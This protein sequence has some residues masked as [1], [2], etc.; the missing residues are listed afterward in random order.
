MHRINGL[1]EKVTSFENLYHA[2]YRVLRGKR[3]Q[4]HAGDFF[5]NLEGNLLRLQRELRARDY[6]PGGYRTFWITEPKP[7]LISAAPF[8][9]RVVHHALVNVIEPIFEAR[10]ISHSYACRTGKGTHRALQQFTAWARSSRYVLKM[11][12]KKFF[13]SI[14]HEVLKQSLRRALKDVHALWLCDLIIDHSNEQ[15]PIMQHFPGDD[16]FTPLARRRGIPIGNLT[17]QFFANVYLDALDH[18]VKERLHLK[19]YLRYVDDFC[20]FHDDK[21]ML[22]ETRQAIAEFLLGLRL[23]LNEGKSRV[24]RLKEGIEFLGFVA[25]P[26]HLRLNQQAVRRQRQRLRQLQHG[27]ETGVL[28]WSEVAASLRAWHAHAA[29]G[30]TWR[31]RAAVFRQAVFTR[32]G[33]TSTQS[34]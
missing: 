28:S 7:R 20:C 8:R 23:R 9:D 27:Y 10:F 11:D 34:R 29:Q 15:E 4:I 5:A 12:I 13:P 21:Q 17:S 33:A 30:T 19:C 31:L 3:G 6:R 1:W 2:A 24:R 16:L 22:T 18:F 14:D 32:P 25:L 26:Y